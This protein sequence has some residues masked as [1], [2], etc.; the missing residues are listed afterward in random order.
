MIHPPTIQ[1]LTNLKTALLRDPWRTTGYCLL[2]FIAFSLPLY[3]TI[4]SQL[5]Y[6]VG[7]TASSGSASSSAVD[8]R[9]AAL[10][11]RFPGAFTVTHNNMHLWISDPDLTNPSA[12]GDFVL[13]TWF[14]MRKLPRLDEKVIVFSKLDRSSTARPGYALAMVRVENGIKPAVYWRGN[15]GAGE[16]FFFSDID[17]LPRYWMF[18]AVSVSQ[19]NTLAVHFARAGNSPELILAGAHVLDEPIVP[20]STDRL[21][22]GSFKGGAFR[23]RLG[24]VSLYNGPSL[25]IRLKPLLSEL[26]TQPTIVPDEFVEPNGTGLYLVD[27]HSIRKQSTRFGLDDGSLTGKRKKGRKSSKLALDQSRSDRN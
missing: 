20:N 21:T 12:N 18:L 7:L 4:S 16:W 10:E 3:W 11:S 23:G 6:S 26:M 1:D 27:Q 14:S 19:G 8:V 15:D 9:T 17:I 13:T 24:P 5:R 22:F 2:F 25:G